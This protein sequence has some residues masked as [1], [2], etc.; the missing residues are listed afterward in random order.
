MIYKLK[1]KL[2]VLYDNIYYK[3]DK[4]VVNIGYVDNWNIYRNLPESPLIFSGGAG[5]DITFELELIEKFNATIHLFDPSPTGLKTFLNVPENDKLIYYQLGLAINDNVIDFNFPQNPEEGSF[6]K[7]INPINDVIK[8]KCIKLS[9]ILC[10]YPRI[11]ILKLDIE[12]FEYEV[13]EDIISNKIF[14][15]QICCE[16]HHYFDS[17]SFLDTLK[18]IFLLK[19]NGYSIK[20]KTQNDFLFVHKD[21]L[22]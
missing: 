11:D 8:F 17:F 5:K 1:K 10:N 6:S 18:I 7:V 4:N 14:P 2:R 22:L 12:G 9:N 3:H 13:I 16:F 15:F 21:L 19:K 20:H